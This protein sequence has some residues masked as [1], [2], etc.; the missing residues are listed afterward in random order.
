MG[1]LPKRHVPTRAEPPSICLLSFPNRLIVVKPDK[2]VNF[3]LYE[4]Y[5]N[6]KKYETRENSPSHLPSPGYNP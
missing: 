1:Y 6:L 2:M 4:F 3:V 5:H